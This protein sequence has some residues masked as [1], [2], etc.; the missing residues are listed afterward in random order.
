MRKQFD[1]GIPVLMEKQHFTPETW[2]KLKEHKVPY[3][4][5]GLSYSGNGLGT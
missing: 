3:G 2:E 4:W 5:R 1:F